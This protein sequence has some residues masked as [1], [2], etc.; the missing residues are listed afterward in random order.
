[1]LR[2]ER[3]VRRISGRRQF[4]G[5]AC[6]VLAGA[7]GLAA[8]GGGSGS[9]GSAAGQK[10]TLTLWQNGNLQDTGFGFMTTVIKNFEKAHPGVTIQVVEKPQDNYF[11]LLQTALISH[12]GPDIADVYAGSY[13]T[14]LTPYLL[15]LNKYVSASVRK[16]L[17]GIAYYSAAGNTD[18]A[19]YAIPSEEQFYNMWYNKALFKKAGVTAPPTDFAEMAADCKKFSAIGVSAYADG[20]PTF[21]TPGAGAV[22]DWSYFA[23]AVYSPKQWNSILD[24]QIPY[25]SPALTA[26]ISSWAS[27]YKAGCSTKNI[28]TQ[29]SDNLFTS[30]KVAM[31]MN[32][33]GL[34]PV[35]SKALGSDLGVMLPPWSVTPQHMMVEL[36]GAGYS[37]A[38]A[39][40]NAKLA[41]QFLAYT[42]TTQSQQIEAQQGGLPVVANVPAVGVP[43]QLLTMARSGKYQ[44][45]P[46]FDNYMQP[47]V[48]AQI[49]TQLPQAFIGQVSARTALANMEKAYTSLPASERKVDYHLGGG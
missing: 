34:Y 32:F 37:V 1:M 20:S 27:L 9:T 11:A 4:V 16:S 22:Q 29:N 25:D 19:T 21:V 44:L 48:V 49:N 15:N 41:A 6:A 31:V 26:E 10:V 14:S 36:P 7:V 28:T 46:M 43:A 35:Y 30:G 18:T 40:P 24:G 38:Q 2:S 23:G 42:V 47:D 12:N 39:S 5:V 45:Y 17:A 3:R 33:N 13:L 8:C